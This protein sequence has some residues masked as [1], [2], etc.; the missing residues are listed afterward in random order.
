MRWISALLLSTAAAL[1]L[2]VR[3]LPLSLDGAERGAEAAV[4]AAIAD[5]RAAIAAGTPPA[6]NAAG[7]DDRLQEE[8]RR[9][10]QYFSYEAPGFGQ[11]PYLGGLDS[12][13][14]L[15]SARN[16]L[17]H[18]TPCDS[19]RDGECRDDFTLAPVGV[20]SR[21]AQSLHVDSIV[22]LHRL[23]SSLRPDFPLALSA[24]LVSVVA[25]TLLVIPAFLLGYRVGG[26]VGGFLCAILCALNPMF[27]MRS[28]GADNDVWNVLL[29]TF[30]VWAAVEAIYSRSWQRGVAFI[31]IAAA[32]AAIHAAIWA[33][34]IFSVAIVLIGL[35]AH[36]LLT[37][38]RWSA[39]GRPAAERPLVIQAVAFTAAF[40][41]A[42]TLASRIAGAETTPLAAA[43]AMVGALPF[44][45]P[46]A[47]S[48]AA[49][50]QWPDV[51]GTVA[52][53]R[54]PGLASIARSMAGPVYFFAGWIGMLLLMLPRSGWNGWH[55][56]VLLGGNLLYRY[57][58]TQSEIA[59]WTLAGLLLLPPVAAGIG[60]VADRRTPVADQGAGA[61]LTIWFLAALVLAH[62]GTRFLI[63][64]APPFAVLCAVAAGRLYFWV[65]RQS[66]AAPAPIRAAVFLALLSFAYPPV[67]AAAGAA[68]NYVPMVNDGWV[69]ALTRLRDE[70]P[71][72]SVVNSWW[73]YGYFI[74]Y[75][76]ER[77]VLADG[78]TLRTRV[79]YWFA[80]ALIADS[81]TES[82][83]ILRMLNCASDAAPEP[84][85]SLGAFAALEDAG[86]STAVAHTALSR[87][88][89][90]RREEALR[91][92]EGMRLS[93]DDAAAVLERTH[94]TPAPAYLLLH[95]DL[96][97]STG[98]RL[99]AG[100]D[101]LESAIIAAGD[102]ADRGAV[103]RRIAAEF[104]VDPSVALAAFDRV[105][106]AGFRR[107][108]MPS[109][110]T[111]SWAQCSGV[112]LLHC[113]V[114]TRLGAHVN[115]RAVSIPAADPAAAA[116]I[117][118]PGRGRRESVTPGTVLVVTPDGIRNLTPGREGSPDS[119]L[120]DPSG[121]H[122]LIGP[123]QLLRST[124]T[125]LMFL[126]GRFLHRFESFDHA[127]GIRGDIRTWR[128]S[129]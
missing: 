110:G 3:L 76:A 17:R 73:D 20:R 105:S 115:L 88:A 36:A 44:F 109:F 118:E 39:Q 83:G 52:E 71:A 18:G 2:C 24:F 26:P 100:W 104:A 127:R 59:P 113:P 124:F 61:L 96:V 57:L 114:G 34:W 56:A 91:Y 29:P 45:A 15:R 98:W 112:E 85:G 70:T 97:R 93:P 40:L 9:R 107:P 126:D 54:Q 22:A 37:F 123:A 31:C 1:V 108:A 117:V 14:W 65:E 87:I 63:L 11:L 41:I 122:V 21:Y 23:T 111:P 7:W 49:A 19:I 13:L 47:T 38:S 78:G 95:D 12:Y 35:A 66:W 92:L 42:A 55:F 94:C 4:R 58:V 50:L 67:T 119:I 72:D 81:E 60:Y 30:Q 16:T 33:G 89:T 80:K 8:R 121:P 116:L 27:L 120:F 53:L 74:K 128:I 75:F 5:E 99:F 84:E 64:L 101:H 68:R 129:W 28:F 90:L 43:A 62:K 79:H 82:I 106:A 32:A 48:A 125:H 77:P 86:L 69:A 25:G 102:R 46:P 51:F 10:R 6:E 103:A